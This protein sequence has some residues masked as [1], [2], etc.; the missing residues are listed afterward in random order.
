MAR[1]ID[2]G[3]RR[4]GDTIPPEVARLTGEEIESHHW[5]RYVDTF[6]AAPATLLHGDPHIGNTYVLPGDEVGFLDW[7]VLRHR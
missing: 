2:I 7:Q 1:G 5:G 4:A 3:L 6:A